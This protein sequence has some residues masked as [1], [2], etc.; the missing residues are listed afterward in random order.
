VKLAA[1]A[2]GCAAVAF[3]LCTLAPPRQTS[4]DTVAGR[5]GG[6]ILRCTGTFDLSRIDWL[7]SQTDQHVELYYMHADEDGEF[8][9]AFGPAPA[10][11]AAVALLDFGSGATM[12]DATLRARERDAAAV[13]LALSVA[14]LVLA[15]GAKADVAHAAGAGLVAALSFAGAATLGQGLWQATVA[16]P[17][18]V[19]ALAAWCWSERFPRLRVVPPA[20]AALAVMLRPTLGP[21]ALGLGVAWAAGKPSRR[22]WLVAGAIAVVAIAPLAV[23]N[24][25]HLGTPL[26]VSQFDNNALIAEQE[27]AAAFSPSHVA[28][29]LAALVASPARG[30]LWF[31]PIALVGAIAGAK[32]ERIVVAAIVLQWLAVATFFKWHGGMAYGPRLLAE[33][34]WLAIWLAAR[35]WPERRGWRAV[36]WVAVAVTCLVGQLGLWSFRA[37]Q[38]ETRLGPDTH[39]GAVWNIVDSP[40]PATLVPRDAP[41]SYDSPLRHELTCTGDMVR[42]R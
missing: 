6:A 16:L 24:L 40:I 1:A 10:V 27:H 38:W 30:V 39:P 23:W 7:R 18:L 26:P 31:A 34:V 19:G 4:G 22:T 11:I 13:L 3:A 36:A 17:A 32:R 9:S 20:L 41:S 15:A 42:T 8:T 2:A 21:L 25:V 5:I 37:E 28:T 33:A 35:A 12:T 29:A 14:L